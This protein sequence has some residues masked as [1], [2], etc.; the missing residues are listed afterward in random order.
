MT[1]RNILKLGELEWLRGHQLQHQVVFPAAGYVSMAIDAA[2]ALAEVLEPNADSPAR[3]VE[4]TGLRFH[5]A[6]TLMTT[7]PPA[8]R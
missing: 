1:W 2:G 4:L 6:I 3:L 7:S 8:L 5:R